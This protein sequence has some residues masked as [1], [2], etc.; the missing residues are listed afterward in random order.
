MTCHYPF[1]I[2]GGTIASLGGPSFALCNLARGSAVRKARTASGDHAS[3]FSVGLSMFPISG[4]RSHCSVPTRIKF[5][6]FDREL[7]PADPS[8]GGEL[9]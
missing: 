6:N 9:R 4:H 3:T 7:P 8:T 2:L 1:W 5:H